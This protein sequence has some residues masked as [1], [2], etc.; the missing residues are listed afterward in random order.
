[1]TLRSAIRKVLSH[2]P[3]AFSAPS[4]IQK[5]IH[6]VLGGLVAE[7]SKIH[8][9]ISCQTS[10][11]V[12]IGQN[13]RIDKG[14][15]IQTDW[16][17]VNQAGQ[18][19]Q[20]TG[21]VVIE[22]N[23]TIGQGITISPNT[24]I[25]EGANINNEND[26]LVCQGIEG[27]SPEYADIAATPALEKKRPVFILGTGRSGTTSLANL[28]ARDDQ[29]TG[30]H[31]A[32][33]WL[34][35]IGHQKH[36][37]GK[38]IEK[39]LLLRWNQHYANTVNVIDSDQRFYNLIPE[40]VRI[41]PNAKFLHVIRSAKSF[42]ASAKSRGW[43]KIPEPTEHRWS[44]YRPIPLDQSKLE[45]ESKTQEER[46]LWYWNYVNGTIQKDFKKNMHMNTET[47]WLEQDDFNA[48]CTAFMGLS[49]REVPRRNTA[50]EGGYKKLILAKDQIQLCD[51]T[52]SDFRH[53][54]NL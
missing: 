31:E 42:V 40:L 5:R 52:E 27:D 50:K 38:S 21:D 26:M 47:L 18:R 34:N 35:A 32:F 15:T 11:G 25:P 9:S 7:N 28:V 12:V 19:I 51:Q 8:P 33:P 4:F 49:T 10:G 48:K 6:S 3:L 1:M 17:L 46:I 22:N 20:G 36:V 23:V 45:W 39:E 44:F 2:L 30:R 29:W 54:W 43:Y 13:E 37:F 16:K 14:V 41:F 53:K 24:L